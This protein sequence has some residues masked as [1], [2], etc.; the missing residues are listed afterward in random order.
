MNKITIIGNTTN[1]VVMRNTPDGTA[2]CGFTVA[3]NNKFKRDDPAQF[4]RVTA[5]RKL[6]ENC[7]KYLPK[8]SKVCVVGSVSL[9]TYT[10]NDGKQG[11]SLEVTA[12]DVE[13][14][15]SKAEA[16]AKSDHMIEQAE[17]AFTDVSGS[18][19][20]ELPF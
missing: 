6:A 8:G 4:F 3:V 15:N 1:D 13:F 5:W 11:A 10:R 9:N 12:E 2:V 17:N 20:D 7:A 14:L 19:S 16:Q 18:V